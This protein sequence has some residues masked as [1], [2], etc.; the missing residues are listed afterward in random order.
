VS[1]A[2]TAEAIHKVVTDRLRELVLAEWP[3]AA[4]T[5]SDF[6]APEEDEKLHI[7]VVLLPDPTDAHHAVYRALEISPERFEQ[8]EEGKTIDA[9]EAVHRLMLN[10]E[11]VFEEMRLAVLEAPQI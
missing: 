5:L 8:A 7:I 3:E 9:T 10:C 6:R 1:R 11:A 4:L 2:D